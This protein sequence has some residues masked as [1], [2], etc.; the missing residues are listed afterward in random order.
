MKRKYFVKKG[1]RFGKLTVINE[2]IK[3]NKNHLV[4]YVK[5]LCD[6]GKIT[7]PDL[8]SLY[9]KKQSTKSCGCRKKE[10]Q[11]GNKNSVTHGFSKTKLYRV[12]IDIKTRT[13]NEKSQVYKDY[14]GRGIFMCQQ[15]LNFENFYNWAI[16]NNYNEKLTIDRIN[17]NNGYYPQN[18]HFT[19][20]SVQMNNMRNNRYI[21][22]LNVKFT[23]IQFCRYYNLNEYKVRYRIKR[24][25]MDYKVLINLCKT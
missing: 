22:V 23:V 6:C 8:L 25:I 16:L 11:K 17:N 3:Y 24:G 12:W 4:R 14:G 15:W 13:T 10:Y 1:Q 7:T 19:N 20:R 18:C 5:C 2:F 9:K 21:F